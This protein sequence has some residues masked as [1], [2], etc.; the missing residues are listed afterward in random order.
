M[1]MV[2]AQ[3]GHLLDPGT[4]DIAQAITVPPGVE[5][6]H[7]LDADFVTNRPERGQDPACAGS[8]EARK[9]PL[10]TLFTKPLAQCSKRKPMM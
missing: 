5:A 9:Q 6:G 4:T 2:G 1:G 8:Q 3:P 10:P 7:E